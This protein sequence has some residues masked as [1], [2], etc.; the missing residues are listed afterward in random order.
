MVQVAMGR[1]RAW[2][3][4]IWTFSAAFRTELD[5]I[6]RKTPMVRAYMDNWHS[7]GKI[8]RMFEEPRKHITFQPCS[9]P[10]FLILSLESAG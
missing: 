4:R 7:I 6:G 5:R 9:L 1:L 2:T 8:L 10:Q 3:C